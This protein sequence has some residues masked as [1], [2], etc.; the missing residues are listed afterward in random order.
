M[1]LAQQYAEAKYIAEAASVVNIMTSHHPTPLM[2]RVLAKDSRN[3]YAA[4]MEMP[5][6]IRAVTAIIVPARQS[7][8]GKNPAQPEGQQYDAVEHPVQK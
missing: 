4:A 8:H 6:A 3:K 2:C 7:R 1:A 5:M